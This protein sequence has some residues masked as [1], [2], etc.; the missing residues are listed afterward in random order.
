MNS[1][2]YT[3][4]LEIKFGHHQ[5]VMHPLPRLDDTSLKKSLCSEGTNSMQPLSWGGTNG[6]VPK[7][8]INFNTN[9]NAKDGI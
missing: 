1:H 6:K 4:V 5:Y 8:Q 7:F 3:K 2:T 9:H